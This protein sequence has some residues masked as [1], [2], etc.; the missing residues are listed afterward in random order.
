M[1]LSLGSWV[2][3]SKVLS[4]DLNEDTDANYP[5]APDAINR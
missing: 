1:N 2:R 5:F 3:G 4:L